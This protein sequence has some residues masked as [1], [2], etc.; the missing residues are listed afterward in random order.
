MTTYILS[1]GM[2]R[3]VLEQLYTLVR[4]V[5]DDKDRDTITY[6][7]A[8]LMPMVANPFA[9]MQPRN[10]KRSVRPGKPQSISRHTKNRKT[11]TPKVSDPQAGYVPD[12]N[13][14][15]TQKGHDW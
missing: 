8:A 10:T 1:P 2:K 11:T 12:P 5:E 9:Y 4:D 14:I 3:R 6:Q 7:T 15:G 13:R